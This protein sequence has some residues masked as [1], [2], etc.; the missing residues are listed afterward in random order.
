MKD[1]QIQRS[2]PAECLAWHPERAILAVGWRRGE[3]TIFNLTEPDLFEQSTV[4][5]KPLVFLVW[6]LTGRRLISGDKVYEAKRA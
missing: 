2:A 5:K 6:N 1:A 3:I 4:H